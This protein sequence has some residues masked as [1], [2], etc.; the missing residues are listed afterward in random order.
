MCPFLGRSRQ[1]Q[2]IMF[3]A[4]I[5][6]A[7]PST[8]APLI[9]IGKPHPPLVL[10]TIAGDTAISIDT[11]RGTKVL[12]IYFATWSPQSI[13]DLAAW[14]ERTRQAVADKKLVLLGVMEE[15]YADRCR[16][17]VQWKGI[18]DLPLLHDPLNLA[19]VAHVPMVVGVDEHGF[20]RVINPDPDRF[21][22]S[23]VRRTFKYD[24]K[25][26][27]PAIE[28]LTDPRYTKRMAGEART[29]ASLR[30]HGDALVLGGLPPQIDEA[31]TTYPSAIELDADDG[32]AFFRLGVAHR[33]R[34]DQPQR[35]PGDF[36][37]AIDAWK[38]A[39]RKNR[40]NAVFRSRLVQYGLRTDR[41]TSMYRWIPTARKKIAARG[42]TP[43]KLAVQPIAAEL[44]KPRKKFKS[45]KSAGPDGDADGGTRP[46]DQPLVVFEAVVVPSVSAKRKRYAQLLLVFRP[47]DRGGVQWDN[48]G[49]PLRVRLE[50]AD[51]VKFSRQF[52][53]FK[54][55]ESAGSSEERTLS[56]EVKLPK[57][58]KRWP[59]TIK[60]HALYR[61]SS[62]GGSA[63]RLLRRDFEVKVPHQSGL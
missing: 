58:S 54:N 24:P 28:N 43:E 38:Q 29:A 13:D 11:Y 31:L 62:G 5:F 6:V 4:A 40:N 14:R 42:G 17:F 30:E 53:A 50:P 25:Q 15:Q 34:Y 44:A 56:F 63:V 16:L 26:R 32:L 36:Q 49:D 59:V 41:T 39:V 2:I 23:F 18:T 3:L 61:I 33:I 10:W 45:V 1:L 57:S 48:R 46:D 51:G 27:R 47:S 37:A 9:A 12:V 7:R 35:Q 8:A 22:K 20:V 19:A 55:P 52:A 60:G 21:E